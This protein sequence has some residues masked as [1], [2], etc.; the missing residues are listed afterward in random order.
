MALKPLEWGSRKE[1]KERGKW[2]MQGN[3]K[4]REETVRKILTP[5][6][7]R[8]IQLELGAHFSESNRRPK[9]Y[10][11]MRSVFVNLLFFFFPSANNET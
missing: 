5:Y 7:Q 6:D 4:R 9:A 11:I 10:E 2:G 1:D 3:K 8:L